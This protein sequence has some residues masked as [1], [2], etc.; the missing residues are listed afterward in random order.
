MEI[1]TLAQQCHKQ[2]IQAVIKK[3]GVSYPK[4]DGLS[5]TDK[6]IAGMI[7]ADAFFTKGI[8]QLDQNNKTTLNWIIT[9]QTLI[10]YV[11]TQCLKNE[12]HE[13]QTEEVHKIQ[14]AYL[15][16]Y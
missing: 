2:H 10:C 9:L 7:F 12:C 15:G 16:H 13:S 14:E 8:C 11:G 5:V 6:N 1:I 4:F 3:L